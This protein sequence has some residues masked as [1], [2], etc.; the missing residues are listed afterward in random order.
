[1]AAVTV[2]AELP[3]FI[4]AGQTIDVTVGSIGNASSLRGGDLLMTPLRGADGEV[5]AMAQGSVVVSGS[6]SRAR[7]A[8]A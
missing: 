4:K 5:Y 8:R 2:T 7:T 1:M 6:A 3:P